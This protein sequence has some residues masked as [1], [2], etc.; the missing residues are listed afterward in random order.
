[1]SSSVY[2]VRATHCTAQLIILTVTSG[3]NTYLVGTGHDRILIDT[4]EGRPEWLASLNEAVSA[5]STN[6]STVILT[7]WHHDH[8][9]GV[10]DLVSL[11]PQAQIYKN[12]P[13]LKGDLEVWKDIQDGQLFKVDGAVLR[14]LHCP[15][16]TTDHMALILEDEDAMF[17][18]DNV[19]GHG[20]AVFEDLATYMSSL[21]TMGSKFGGRAYPG[22]GDVIEDGRGRISQYISHRKQRE[23]QVLE[24]LDICGCS[25]QLARCRR[26]GCSTDTAQACR[27]GEGGEGAGGPL[28]GII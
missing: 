6:I 25:G 26:A 28:A 9:S 14:A 7:H 23:D 13:A 18:G 24:V 11:F 1:M 16:H 19:L 22:H 2:R 5:E 17:T 27:R 8:I 20:T 10:P 4:G 3:T 21:E 12:N 15:G